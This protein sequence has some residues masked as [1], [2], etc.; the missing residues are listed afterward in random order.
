MVAGAERSYRG[1][2]ALQ[3]IERGN[4]GIM[5]L[6]QTVLDGGNAAYCTVSPACTLRVTEPTAPL[7]VIE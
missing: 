6:F 3:A 1:Y 4:A 5:S 7:T 2:S